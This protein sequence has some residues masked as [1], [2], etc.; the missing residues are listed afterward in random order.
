MLL[1]HVSKLGCP[2][3]SAS[4]SCDEGEAAVA[5]STVFLMPIWHGTCFSTN[6][7]T[8]FSKYS[9]HESSTLSMLSSN[10]YGHHIHPTINYLACG[11]PTWSRK[12]DF[13][14]VGPP[15]DLIKTMHT[16]QTMHWFLPKKM[17]NCTFVPQCGVT[18]VT[19]MQRPKCILRRPPLIESDVVTS[20]IYSCPQGVELYTRLDILNT[21]TGNK[22]MCI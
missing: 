10:V 18:V 6:G 7:P 22:L 17:W 16:G 12:T 13:W 3:L 4:S 1:V 5:V 20:A 14:F 11:L 9:T 19:S 2:Q 8:F 15:L 21:N